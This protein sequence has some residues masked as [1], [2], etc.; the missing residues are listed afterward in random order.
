MNLQGLIRS[1]STSDFNTKI[2]S[3]A[4]ALLLD[5]PSAFHF[6]SLYLALL[7]FI[8]MVSS[9]HGNS[10]KD[11]ELVLGKLHDA[12]IMTFRIGSEYLLYQLTDYDPR[13]RK[14]AHSKLGN[15][16]RLMADIKWSLENYIEFETLRDL[17]NS[18]EQF[19]R[20][21]LANFKTV[22]VMGESVNSQLEELMKSHAK[23]LLALKETYGELEVSL[24]KQ[25]SPLVQKSRRDALLIESISFLY[26]N[27]VKKDTRLYFYSDSTLDMNALCD[28]FE[29]A[30]AEMRIGLIED[31]R[32]RRELKQVKVKFDFIE[33]SLRD[34]NSRVVP[35]LV[36][37]YS[38]SI[39]KTLQ[40]IGDRKRS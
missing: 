4:S 25:L 39:V 20:L 34:H 1:Y 35:E 9:A 3:D 38:E 22:D 11:D 24:D 5:R 23:L 26:M 7:I 17:N 15:V 30:L 12:R 16:D 10:T 18:W 28:R 13:F 29:T 14:S 33:P 37:R 27:K 19:E 31:Q 21:Q 8:F 40:Y 2:N 32:S 6:L 36:N